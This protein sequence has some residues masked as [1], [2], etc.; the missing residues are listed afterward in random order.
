MD[1]RRLIGFFACRTY[2]LGG[3]V[4]PRIIFIPRPKYAER[5]YSFRRFRPSVCLSVLPSVIPS[6]N[7]C[8]N[9]VLLRSFLVMYISTA[10]YQKLFI[11]GMGVPGR[12]HFHSTSLDRSHSSETI[13]IWY[14]ATWEDSLP[15]YIYGTLA[16]APW[17]G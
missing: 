11:F 12:V 16:H 14:G 2:N 7:T 4:V 8:Y 13:H 15:F 6:V 17:R 9:Q 5:V 3:N 10:T 1:M